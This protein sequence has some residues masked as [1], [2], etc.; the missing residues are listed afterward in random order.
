M[1]RLKLLIPAVA[2]VTMFTMAPP[3]NSAVVVKGVT[4]TSG[5]HWKPKITDI[6][7]GTKVTWK[8]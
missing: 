1:R 6:A 3:A 5:S 2:L 8:A 4:T 7:S